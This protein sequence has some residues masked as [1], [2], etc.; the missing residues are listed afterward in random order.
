MLNLV[1]KEIK[2]LAENHL[3]KIEEKYEILKSEVIG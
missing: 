1:P 3:D 2:T